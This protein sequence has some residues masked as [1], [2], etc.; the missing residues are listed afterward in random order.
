MQCYHDINSIRCQAMKKDLHKDYAALPSAATVPVT[1]KYLFGDPSKLTKD[2]SEANKLTKKVCHQSLNWVRY[3][4]SLSMR[5]RLQ[6]PCHI[7]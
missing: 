1:S 7:L 2:I 6:Q 3:S 5:I 4:N